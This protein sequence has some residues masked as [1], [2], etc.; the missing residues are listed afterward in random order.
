M[1]Q[2]SLQNHPNTVRL[3]DYQSPAFLIDSVDLRFE[4]EPT[5][6]MVTSELRI[7]RNP[8][9]PA[10]TDLRLDGI[11]LTLISIEVDGTPL[12]R[13]QYSLDTQAL[14]IFAPLDSFTLTTKAQ[15]NPKDN[16]ALEG[17]YMSGPIYCTQCEA[18]GFRKITWYLDRPDVMAKFTTTVVADKGSCPV[19]LSNGNPIERG[20]LPHGKHFVVWEDPFDKPAYLFAL[21]AGDLAHV[22]DTFV[23]SS[24]REVDLRIYVEHHNHDRCDHAMT[25]LKKSMTWDEQVYG[26]EYDLDIFM[27][28]AVDDFNMGAME[29]K[30]LN[31][32]NSK[33]ILAKPSTATDQDYAAIEGVVAH[34]YFHNWTGNRVTCRDWFQL[35]LKEGLTVFRDQEFS[36][37]MMSRPV[38]RIQDV[39]LLR[40]HQFLE[41]A[42]PMAHP[43]R[44]DTYMEI[45]NFYTVT[46][47]NKGAEV[48]RMLHSVVGQE[49]F[50]KGMDLYFERHDGQAVTT[51]DFVKA[52][53]AASEQDLSQFR[54]WY[55]QAGT[56][57]VRASGTFDATRR[58]Y[59]LRVEQHCA[60]T[61]GQTDKKP[62]H[63]PLRVGLLNRDGTMQTLH[64]D[65]LGLDGMAETVLNV[66][67]PVE[68]FT[69]TNVSDEPVPSI[70]RGF[71]APIKVEVPRN[72]Q[73]Q[74]HLIGHETDPFNRWDAAQEYATQLLLQMIEAHQNG[75][76]PPATDRF[77]D[78]FA[79]TLQAPDLD[80]AFIAEALALPAESYIASRCSPIEP[81]VIHLMRQRLRQKIGS[82]LHA[83][84]LAVYQ[85]CLSNEPYEF[86]PSSAGRRNLKKACLSYL[87][88][89]GEDKIRDACVTQ[90]YQAD[91]MTDCLAAL[92]PLTHTNIPQR[93]EALEAYLERWREDP[94][95]MDK[96]FTLQALSHRESTLEEVQSLLEHPSFDVKNPNKVR[97]L[98]GAFCHTNQVRFHDPSGRGYRFLSEQVL[99][100]DRMNPQIAARLLGA[101]SRWRQF[102]AA[103]QSL[104]QSELQRILATTGLSKDTYEIASKTL[105]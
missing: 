86:T 47:Y 98:I 76:E 3:S 94:L 14:T 82:R 79:R 44:P 62:F 55:T 72:A 11:D 38:K 36:A 80:P 95:A 53:E 41:D 57:I 97:S 100:I 69:F 56:P 37:D 51:E 81:E 77:V 50:R 25:S 93:K 78:A 27:I 88:E 26:L 59:T 52:M 39:R 23:T 33:Y 12:A 7:R 4:L 17:L 64:C 28:V 99:K 29:N 30:G 61:P 48:I 102:N 31:I 87:M 66:K 103:R 46:I 2:D 35:S 45:S 20:E 83:P 9:G 101:F 68:E 73:D 5:K 67:Q 74:V 84:L 65:E 10:S 34:E 90:F 8:N 42:G 6:T 16:T 91:N 105:G 104:M 13:Q 71:S 75:A 19:L 54:L 32:F 58:H 1:P 89:A 40:T 18:E 15:V 70:A 63:I 96:W 60:P 43:V 22:Q 49:N 85:S 92:E 21:V 24:G